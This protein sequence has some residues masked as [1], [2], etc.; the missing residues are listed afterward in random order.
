MRGPGPPHSSALW[1]P[2]LT[3]LCPLTPLQRYL[4]AIWRARRSGFSDPISARR[5]LSMLYT[6]FYG[7]LLLVIFFAYQL[8][9]YLRGVVFILYR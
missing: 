3:V 4:L 1:L 5:E 2:H 7:A 6:R 8:Q 9:A